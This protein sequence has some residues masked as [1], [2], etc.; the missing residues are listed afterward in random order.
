VQVYSGLGQLN[1][2]N[3]NIRTENFPTPNCEQGS[4]AYN[5]ITW[6]SQAELMGF[7]VDV[8]DM[9]PINSLRSQT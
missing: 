8:V 2:V 3:T 4:Q 1:D 7:S 9:K 5:I 6:T